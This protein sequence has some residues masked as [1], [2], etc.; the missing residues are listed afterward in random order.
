MIKA[1]PEDF[2]VEERADLPL[3]PGGRFGVYRLEKSG[4]NT[5]DLVRHLAGRF[6]LPPVRFAYGGKKDKHGRTSQF[7][8]IDGPDDLRA[9]G[10][11]FRL[12]PAGRMDR[13]MGPDLIQANGFTVVIRALARLETLEPALEEIRRGGFPNWFDDQR[14][15]SYDPERGFFAEK[16]LRRHWNGALQAFLTSVTP[17]LSGRERARKAELFRV[18]RDWKA[19]RT[20]AEL[21]L[22]RA[23]FD[24]L[25]NRPGDLTEA[26]H[27]IPEEET[28]MQFAA[29]QSHLWNELLRRII[30]NRDIP[31]SEYAGREGSYLFWRD[32][33]EAEKKFGRPAL[34]LPTASVKMEFPDGET[35]TLFDDLLRERGLSRAAFRTKE[36]R[37]VRFQS[38]LRPVVVRPE[39]FEVLDRGEDELHPG[40][41]KI[42]LRF[43]LPRGSYATILV[44]RLTLTGPS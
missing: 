36:L 40:R 37:R 24:I 1:R 42:T 22:E 14:F 5:T 34:R 38:F 15:R 3:V 7:I 26:L 19:C 16:I 10:K 31:V 25:R 39:G 12:E 44:K 9:S 6:R 27:R 41:K 21:P 2:L 13:P 35:E 11:D 33:R 4:W 28:A 17:N 30:R 32:A 29:F 43:D 20:L 23:V 18:W 8:T